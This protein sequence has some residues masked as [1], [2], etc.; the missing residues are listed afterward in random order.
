MRGDGLCVLKTAAVQQVS[1]DARRAEGMAVGGRS[2]FRLPAASLD[3]AVDID[4]G[5]AAR[6]PFSAL[7][8]TGAIPKVGASC[9]APKHGSVHDRA[10][11]RRLGQVAKSRIRGFGKT[12]AGRNED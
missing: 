7:A 8:P 9:V 12:N 2:Q 6:R 11:L 1:D 5:E 4:A 3:H 10:C